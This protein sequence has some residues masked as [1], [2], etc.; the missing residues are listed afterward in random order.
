VVIVDDY[1]GFLE[2]GAPEQAHDELNNILMQRA[3]N[4]FGAK[5]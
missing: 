3:I 1:I 2:E 5:S 4:L